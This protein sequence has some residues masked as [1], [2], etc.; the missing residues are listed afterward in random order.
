MA[1][2]DYA[3]QFNNRAPDPLQPYHTGND[4]QS[5]EEYDFWDHLDFVIAKA[6]EM[7]MYV[8]LHPA[9]G[10][11]F[12]GEYNGKPNRFIIFNEE[13]A[14]KYGFWIGRRYSEAR[15]IVWMVGGDR[16]AVYGKLDYRSVFSAM[17]RGIAD[18]VKGGAGEKDPLISFHPRKWA[19]NSSE[20][21][22]DEPWLSFNSIQDTP[23]DQ[24]PPCRMIMD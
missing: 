24:L 23:Y 18:G 6:N 10:D 19:P 7:G 5:P 16:S 21:F 8:V 4:P 2:D 17:G 1:Q 14:Y 12:T 22:H 13:N 3:F 15:N 11:W 9:W 20:W